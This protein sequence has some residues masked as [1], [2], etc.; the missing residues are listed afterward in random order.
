M[1]FDV[2]L[3][4]GA[5]VILSSPAAAA[6]SDER[7]LSCGCERDNL[8]ARQL[9]LQSDVCDVWLPVLNTRQLCRSVGPTVVACAGISSDD[10]TANMMHYPQQD[11]HYRLSVQW[12]RQDLV[13]K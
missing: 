8:L 2:G 9:G 3:L 12:R 11:I 10:K 1:L 5:A 4:L 6:D 13:S 7:S